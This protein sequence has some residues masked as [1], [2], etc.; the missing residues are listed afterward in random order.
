MLTLRISTPEPIKL[1]DGSGI[2]LPHGSGRNS[3]P[4]SAAA[5]KRDRLLRDVRL[6]E[7]A[8]KMA[9]GDYAPYILRAVTK[10]CGVHR[11][12]ADGCPCSESTFYRLRRRFFH[13]LKE[14][15]ENT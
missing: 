1:P 8:A 7:Q 2:F 6:I 15:R 3:D 12:I 9:A 13:A 5:E 10:R 4:V 14:L 11:I